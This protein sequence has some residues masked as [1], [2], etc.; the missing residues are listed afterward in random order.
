MVIP[1]QIFFIFQ[2]IKSANQ[3]PTDPTATPPLSDIL[4]SLPI[5][6]PPKSYRKSLEVVVGVKPVLGLDYRT[7]LLWYIDEIRRLLNQP[8]N[9]KTIDAIKTKIELAFD[10]LNEYDNIIFK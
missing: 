10:Y 1:F 5:F 2:F 7:V 3:T 4:Y 8:I 6:K 9:R